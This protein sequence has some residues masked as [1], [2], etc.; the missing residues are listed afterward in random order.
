M[1]AAEVGAR[2]RRLVTA[3]AAARLYLSWRFHRTPKGKRR[4]MQRLAGL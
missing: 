1:P 2:L 4:V 3:R